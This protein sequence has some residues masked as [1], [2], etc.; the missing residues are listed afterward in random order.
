MDERGADVAT[1]AN[2]LI[3]IGVDTKGVNGDIKR[4]EAQVSKSF[5]SVREN[6][7]AMLSSILKIATAVPT[8]ATVAGAAVSFGAA[9]AGAGIG[10]GVF[11]AVA[12]TAMSDVTE[13]AKK[14]ED[15]TD[16]IALLT[17]E[18]KLAGKYGIEAG[19]IAKER[20][21]AQLELEARLKNMG[22]AER[23]ATMGFIGMKKSW[24]DFVDKNKPQ[25][26]GI[27]QKGYGLIGKVI[28][29]LQPFFDMGAKAA[30]RLLDAMSASVSGGGI[31]R[32]AAKAGPALD[33]LVKIFINTGRA[34][35]GMFAK[36]GNTGQGDGML[37][38]LADAT[39]KWNGW[40]HASGENAGFN[41]L[42]TFMTGNGGT[43]VKLLTDIA[44]AALNI[45]KAVTPLAPITLALAGALT[46]LIAAVPPAV[47]TAIVAAFVAYGIAVKAYAAYGVV[48]AAVQWAM[49]SA[50]LASPIT[51]IVAGILLVVGVIIYLAT[52]TKFFQTVWA[53]V[54]GFLKAVGSWF[55]GPFANFFVSAWKRVVSMF[56]WAKDAVKR[57][58]T[59]VR[60]AIAIIWTT[61]QKITNQVI[62]KGKSFIAWFMQ[63]P[64]KIAGSLRNMFSGLWQGFRS[65]ANKIIGGW[66]RLQFT[67]GGGSVMGV[68]IPSVS[69]GTP[70][71][72]YL[73]KGGIVT[74]PTLAMIGEGRESEVVAPLS[75]LPELAG[76]GD[77]VVQVEIV[78]GGEREFRRWIK[79]S[80]RV[81]G[82][83][84]TARA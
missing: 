5:N 82:P 48:A 41:K 10:M 60:L 59:A 25:T 12:K 19:K 35:T 39:G 17:T 49:N 72:P 16:K 73:A 14:V 63:M 13:N 2:L 52:K 42:I 83:I 21:K 3:Q 78:P 9:F 69:L 36:M 24:T 76:R 8:L 40:V 64:G 54:W 50:M 77:T 53:G 29:K 30:G 1:L 34:V 23:G 15:L 71:I 62:N 57:Q 32:L 81:T 55:A 26:F 33:N 47:L 4:F 56:N 58:M 18:E 31:E 65:V 45:L 6:S 43:V 44:A 79:K 70:D 37:T 20:A 22:P 74:G 27:L 28:S 68:S 61:W 51:W 38:W 67:I 7:G 66:N 75:K 84:Q 80:I 46:A 11:G